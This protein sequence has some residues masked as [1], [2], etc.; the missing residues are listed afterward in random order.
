MP[1][2]FLRISFNLKKNTYQLYYISKYY[3]SAINIGAFP[4]T[5]ISEQWVA[6]EATATQLNGLINVLQEEATIQNNEMDTVVDGYIEATNN[7]QTAIVDSSYY[8][9][10]F[11]YIGVGSKVVPVG[12]EST[13]CTFAAGFKTAENGFADTPVAYVGAFLM[14]GPSAGTGDITKIRIFV[15]EVG[16]NAIIQQDTWF[17]AT[18]NL[19]KASKTMVSYIF[20]TSLTTKR[21]RITFIVS[22]EPTVTSV[23]LSNQSYGWLIP[24]DPVY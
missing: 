18:A 15:R 12:V 17:G 8:Q 11:E 14:F 1:F 7:L 6:L 20:N 21:Y 19:G 23:A 9:N 24:M 16:T 3:M 10:P 4:L 22:A 2:Y 13:L 5:A